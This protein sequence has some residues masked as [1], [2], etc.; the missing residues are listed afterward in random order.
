MFG[1]HGLQKSGHGTQFAQVYQDKTLR[2]D[3]ICVC[4]CL[5]PGNNEVA[6]PNSKGQGKQKPE[7]NKCQLKSVSLNLKPS[8]KS[9]RWQLSD[10]SHT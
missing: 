6:E 8:D 10:E 1:L 2:K 4:V 5:I 3:V 9:M 7:T